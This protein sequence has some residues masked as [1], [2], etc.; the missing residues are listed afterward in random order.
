MKSVECKIIHFGHSSVAV[1]TENT[2]LI[3]DYYKDIFSFQEEAIQERL[4]SL[5]DLKTDKDVFV[6]V[7]H[8]HGDHFNPE[9]FQ[10]KKFNKRIQYILGYDI[11]EMVH[12]EEYYYMEPLGF[13]QLE[14]VHIKSFGSTDKGVSFLVSVDDF[15][16]F[17]AGDLNWWHWKN[18]SPEEQKQEEVDFKREVNHLRGEAIDIAF[19]PADPRL[20]EFFHLAGLYFSQTLRPQLL[21]PIHFRENYSICRAFAEKLGDNTVKVANF[22]AS[23]QIITFCNHS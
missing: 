2:F 21:V 22:T 14:G 9:I 11:K 6:F 17:H 7:S 20:D 18:F 1:E 3:F 15:T 13:L 12:E 16:I 4:L 5:N 10:W 19:I 8:G 23:G